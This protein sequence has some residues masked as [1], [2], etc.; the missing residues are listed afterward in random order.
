M[1]VID[2]MDH[3]TVLSAD[4][5]KT[6]A[7]YA[8]FGLREG[9]RPA[10]PFPGLW[11]YIDGRAVLHVIA[12]DA[13]PTPP[14]GA[15]DHIAFRASDLA[16]TVEK[17]KSRGLPYK[18]LRLPAPYEDWQLFFRDPFGALVEFDYTASEEPP[19]DWR[20]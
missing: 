11:L 9:P 5:D 17:L 16:G 15:I 13:V 10:F 4:L 6:R 12:A 8:E 20:A 7:F 3:F 19:A 18:L 14:D 1:S 2:K